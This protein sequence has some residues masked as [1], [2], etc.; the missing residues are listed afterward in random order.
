VLHPPTEDPVLR[1]SYNRSTFILDQ[2]DACSTRRISFYESETLRN[3]YK[4][5]AGERGRAAVDIL[6]IKDG[7]ISEHW[8]V[9]QAV[10]EKPAN[11]HPLCQVIAGCGTTGIFRARRLRKRR[12][13]GIRSAP[14]WRKVRLRQRKSPPPSEGRRKRSRITW[15]TFGKASIPRGA[16]CRRFRP[17]AGSA[18]SCSGSGTVSR[19]R[20]DVPSA[21]EKR[22]PTH[23]SAWKRGERHPQ[24]RVRHPFR[25]RPPNSR[26]GIPFRHDSGILL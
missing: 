23:L 7:K 17:N 21:R 24:S 15:N 11:P 6:R 19:R 5:S 16:G 9:L 22:F 1:R 20:A 4:N 18:G 13:S 10:R 8:D 25:M 14:S 12:P 2:G 3:P 26:F